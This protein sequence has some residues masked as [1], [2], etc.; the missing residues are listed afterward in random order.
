MAGQECQKGPS[1]IFPSECR[2]K[3]DAKRPVTVLIQISE[4]DFAFIPDDD[5]D[6]DCLNSVRLHEI[7]LHRHL[8]E[9]CRQRK[10]P[11][12]PDH[13]CCINVDDANAILNASPQVGFPM[14]IFQ[15]FPVVFLKMHFTTLLS[16]LAIVQLASAAILQRG[17]SSPN[18]TRC[19]Q[20][21]CT[22]WHESG[23]INQKLPVQPGNVRQS[24][25][26]LVQV[27]L[28]GTKKFYNSFVYESIPR[29]GK[30]RNFSPWDLPYSETL[31]VTIDDGITVEDKVEINMAWSEFEYNEDVDLKILR[32]DGKDLGPVSNVVIRPQAYH[33]NITTS[34]D[35]GGVIIRIPKE[36]NGRR[37]SVE[38]RDDLYTYRSNGSEGYVLS[39]AEVVGVEPKNALVIFASAFQPAALSPSMSPENTTTM[40]PG[41]IENGDW[42]NKPILYFPPGVYWISQNQSGQGPAYGQNHI[43]LHP[44]TYWVH[45]APGAYLKGAIEYSTSH[46]DFYATG[47][48]ILSGEHYVYQANILQSYQAI[49]SDAT[50]LRLWFHN[51]TVGNQIWH[52]RGPTLAN[53][54]FNTMDFYAKDSGSTSSKTI[55]TRVADYK[56][57]GA[58]YYQTDGP[59]N[60]ANS[61]V[62]HVFY[63]VNDDGI[64]AYYDNVT[65]SNVTIWAGHNDPIIQ[66]GWS[67]R[68]VSGVLIDGLNVIH[69]RH[70]KANMVVPSAIIGASPFYSSGLYVDNASTISLT[71]Q[72][73]V[74]EGTCPSLFR[75]N[76]LQNYHNFV[77]RNVAFPDGIVD[78]SLEIGQ[79][80]IPYVSNVTMD[81]RI[82]NWTVGGVK[83]TETNYEV[84]DLGQ[85]NISS[86]Y[87][88]Q[89][90]LT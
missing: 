59:Q 40:K 15:V 20:S 52:C 1:S 41:P 23:E 33:F 73:V 62:N 43:K 8:Q 85:F 10:A 46:K 21:L 61:R 70:T 45:F 26:Y 77:V 66:M 36:V 60:Y 79:S 17:A 81:L 42:G 53:P 7:V 11:D 13:I 86:G 4:Q 76:P 89:W 72:N 22:W 51:N 64:K 80:V 83:I 87:E 65:I 28:A 63:H 56:Q 24:R 35:D 14:I 25:Q 75:I 30:G 58:W 84:G 47:H 18:A 68:N 82:S 2:A 71:V 55:S 50:S 29:N 69:T 67:S 31:N 57:V 78:N 12:S 39:G 32:R 19:D 9:T 3:L 49:K 88:G 5:L 6:T 16:T 54:P 34:T 27:A 90:T 48:G 38:F 74:C 44:D 37:F